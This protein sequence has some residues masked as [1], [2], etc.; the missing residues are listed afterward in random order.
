MTSFFPFSL[1]LMPSISIKKS[2]PLAILLPLLTSVGFLGWIGFENGRRTA[3]KLANQTM[4]GLS[5]QIDQKLQNFLNQPILINQ[6]NANAI[7]LNQFDLNKPDSFQKH[8]WS[9]MQLFK[10]VNGIQFGYESSGKLRGI[11]REKKQGK[12]ILTYDAADSFDGKENTLYKYQVQLEGKRAEKAFDKFPN[13]LTRKRLWYIR[14]KEAQQATWTEIF[15]KRTSETVQLRLTAVHPVYS[16]DDKKLVGVLAVDFFLSQISE[17][18]KTVNKDVKQIDS[19]KI[20]SFILDEKG[21]LVASSTE[22]SKKPI[23]Q[24]IKENSEKVQR[25]KASQSND[26]LIKVT[27]IEIEKRFQGDFDKV[28]G[29]ASDFKLTEGVSEPQRIKV[30]RFKNKNLDWLVV[31]IVPD[32]VFMESIQ[33]TR[34]VAL[35]LAIGTVGF[36]IVLGLVVTRW[37]IN[38]ILQL[39]NAAEKIVSE[40]FDPDSLDSVTKRND[41]IGELARVFQQMANVVYTREKSLKQQ[42]EDLRSETDRA[43]KA[44][45]AQQLT[46]NVDVQALLAR[47]QKARLK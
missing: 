18:L 46:G 41:E 31:V 4:N 20:S 23:F 38:P 24:D 13:Y 5:S 42:V 30:Q 26:S 2:A 15:K 17:F 29:Q 9:Q 45:V 32:Q 11:V 21:E 6:I 7:Q 8:F 27:G 25:L 16:Q 12:E 22:S 3:D 35:I 39:N 43:K 1:Q 36:S 44:A 14:A 33:H 34:N 28:K 47:S 10:D 40:E 19:G 37:L